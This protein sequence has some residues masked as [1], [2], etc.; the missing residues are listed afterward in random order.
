MKLWT[1]LTVLTLMV[2]MLLSFAN[3]SYA[4]NT[5]PEEVKKIENALPQK[6]TAQPRQ[7]R[8]LLVFSLCKGYRHSA[9]PYINKALELMGEKTK[10]FEAT[11]SEDMTMFRPA[12]LKQFD[13]VC[14][15]N[16]TNLNFDDEP[17][18]RE[19]LMDF[20]KSGKGIV[21]IHAGCD[22]F[23]KWPEAREMMG[24]FFTGH[25]W[26]AG[27]TWK[28]KIED[29][30]SPLTASFTQKEFSLKE[31]IYRT[32]GASL[33][34]SCRVLLGLDTTDEA[35]LSARGI[36]ANDREVA[37][38]WI[39]NF[40]KGKLFYCG[41]GHNHE[42]A[43]NPQILKHYLDGIQF[44]MGDLKADATPIPVQP[45]P[46]MSV[47]LLGKYLDKIA[48][49]DYGQS[50][51]PLTALDEF[52]GTAADQPD[53]LKLFEKRMATFL[54][55][56]KEVTL[57]AKDFICR[58][59][60]I[61]GTEESPPRLCVLLCKPDTADMARYAVER[62]PGEASNRVLKMAMASSSGRIRIGIINTLGIRRD[63][64]A[65]G[66]LQKLIYDPDESTAVAAV[67][68]LGQIADAAA[69]KALAKA[70]D[71]VPA[72][73][74]TKVL[75]A[76]LKCADQMLANGKKSDALAIYKELYTPDQVDP[77]RVAAFRA[78]VTASGKRGGAIIISALKGN[79]VLI[80]RTDIG[81]IREISDTETIK[82]LASRLKSLSGASQLQLITALADVGDK[83]ALKDVL[84]VAKSKNIETATA[85]IAAL[86]SL[87]DAST[88]KLLTDIAA[89]PDSLYRDV[90]RNSLYVL[91]SDRVDDTIIKGISTAK[92]EV[93]IELIKAISQ[94]RIPSAVKTLLVTA[95][96]SNEGV[97]VESIKALRFVNNQNLP[98]LVALMIN[99]Q[100]RNERSEGQ[101]TV[102]AVAGEMTGA[103]KKPAA[104]VV[105][106]M[107]MAQTSEA[108]ASM[109][110]VLGKIG[111]D[112][113][114]STLRGVFKDSDGT[115][116]DA[117]VRAL[118]GWPTDAAMSDLIQIAKT[119][120]KPARR[121]L[122]LRGYIKLIDLPSS[123]S[124]EQT[125]KLLA[126]AIDVSARPDEKKA[127]IAVL[128]KYSSQKALSLAEKCAKDPALTAEA[129]LAIARIKSAI[130]KK[131]LKVSASSNNGN[132]KNAI[133]GNKRTRWDT[134]SAMKS[135]EWFVL[136]MGLEN[137][138]K[139]ITL[140]AARSRSDYPRGCEVYVSNDGQSWGD[141]VLVV[142][143]I[144]RSPTELTLKEPVTTRYIKIVQAGTS[145]NNHWSIHD[146]KLEFE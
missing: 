122:A 99:A 80:Q 103:G 33:R 92:P 83:A 91:S 89:D 127:A 131:N 38:S 42:I 27:G 58:K 18:L 59:L 97:R 139:K 19:S 24:N 45:Q 124:G 125:V 2:C 8:K 108:R 86:G 115:V 112:T 60:S 85:A 16:S 40:G 51:E 120:K 117:V 141:A 47:V 142:K 37:I 14:F 100:T 138:V 52:I 90:A 73:L 72:E 76:Y 126:E 62:I 79:D 144:K 129:K 96:D 143:G 54:L 136:D 41:F 102:V 5:K 63:A 15:N 49:Y 64:K 106:M 39:R 66:M 36:I 31:E 10:A 75:D 35:N 128:A 7:P 82:A 84:A 132:A 104:I 13:A 77:I 17:G 137:P 46:V 68:S 26:T 48:S 4:K 20:I 30:A 81:L 113:T 65:V 55:N 121:I 145:Q 116:K 71:K 107:P 146:I 25:P 94:R 123:R 130:A 87:G 88:V 109:A 119:T 6:A 56:F 105:G 114:L 134:G 69:T 1:K 21:G 111:D 98:E 61:I 9:I 101:R 32:Q 95:Q 140:D 44:A 28:V 22:N 34:K 110:S 50:R 67:A 11:V 3:P 29:A 53:V 118:S 12:N 93:K 135:G 23:Q 57:A 70:K 133:D 74:K 43:W 78:M